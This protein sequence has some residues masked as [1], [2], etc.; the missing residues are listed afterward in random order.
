MPTV[1]GIPIPAPSGENATGD[2]AMARNMQREMEQ[3][4]AARAMKRADQQFKDEEL[5]RNFAFLEAARLAS[6]GRGASPTG[7]QTGRTRCCRNLS[8]FVSTFIVTASVLVIGFV[9]FGIFY[10]KAGGNLGNLPPWFKDA[11]GQGWEG[12]GSGEA[13]GSEPGELQ[14]WK[15]RKKNGMSLTLINALDEKWHPIFETAVDE[16]NSGPP[17]ALDLTTV[18]DKEGGKCET[19]TRGK[20]KVCNDDY[21]DT[22]WTGL[23]EVIFQDGYIISS[24]AMMNEFYLS[25]ARTVEKQYV[26][27]HELGHGWGLPHRDEIVGNKDLGT[28]MDYTM[29]PKNNKQPDTTDFE[30][31]VSLY[32]EVPAERRTKGRLRGL[33]QD[34]G[35]AGDESEEG[36]R[37]TGDDYVHELSLSQHRRQGRLLHKTE[38]GEAWTTDLGEGRHAV[39]R[40]LYKLR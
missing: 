29:S 10:Q 32:G 23:N 33:R 8:K 2:E 11:W 38:H 6:A 22:D 9:L 37:F 16:W 13:V 12:V 35:S 5:A 1:V 24:V 34:V 15:N 14:S 19:H 17:R 40:L 28:C 18:M 4:A 30:N 31:L 20:V 25:R 3:A 39:V 27:C 21:G 36:E 7:G 26:M